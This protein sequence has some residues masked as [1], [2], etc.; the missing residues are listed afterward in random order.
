MPFKGEIW[1]GR[2]YARSNGN[3][4]I[5][6]RRYGF[7]AH[8]RIAWVAHFNHP[9]GARYLQLTIWKTSTTPVVEVYKPLRIKI[10][11]IRST[12]FANDVP[13]QSFIH[14]GASAP[15]KYRLRYSHGRHILAQGSFTLNR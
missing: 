3:L 14:L 6:G 4:V 11:D 12:E 8:G 10:L 5:R 15:G 9:A 1:F 7:A 2:G 13:V